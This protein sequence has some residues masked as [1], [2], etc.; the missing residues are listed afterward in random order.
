MG[1]GAASFMN[2][3]VFIRGSC[4]AGSAW[5]GAKHELR[6]TV[7]TVGRWLCALSSFV[8]GMGAGLVVTVQTVGRF[9]C[10]L[11]S[12]VRGGGRRGGA[13]R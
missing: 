10:V 7:H 8:R 13:G 1:P 12:L 2:I 4:A 11:S 5:R 6:V 9:L 3:N